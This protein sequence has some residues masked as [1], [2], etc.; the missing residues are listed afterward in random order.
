VSVAGEH[1]VAQ[2][3]AVEDHDER[4]A[5][6]LAIGPMIPR[7]TA[8]RQRVRFRLALEICARDIIEQHL[9]LNR[10][11]LTAALRQMRFERLFMQD[12]MR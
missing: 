12:E 7:V 3:K 10:K 6:L 9:I 1:L 11:Q 5:Y 2:W 4:D 8:L